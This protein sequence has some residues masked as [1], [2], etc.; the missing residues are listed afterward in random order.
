MKTI[1]PLH[2]DQ[3]DDKPVGKL[4]SRREVLALLGGSSAALILG[5]G[6]SSSLARQSQAT[7][8]PAGT[9]LPSCVVRPEMTEG[10]YF[11]DEQLNRID[12][13]IDPTDGNIKDGVPLWVVFNVSSVGDGTCTPIAGAQIDV[14]SCDA[15]GVY[16]GVSDAG[17]ETVGQKWLRG[18]QVTD[19]TG[20]AQ[21][22]SVFPGWYSGRT[23][24][25]HFK[26]RTD[27]SAE[28]S[29]EFTSQLFFPEELIDTVYAQA[30]YSTKSG[31]RDTTNATDMHYANGGDQLLMELTEVSTG[32]MTSVVQSA[33]ASVT[34]TPQAEVPQGYKIV[35]TI[36]LDLTDTSVGASDSFSQGGG[37]GAGGG[38][39]GN[40]PGGAP[41]ATP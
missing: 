7:S 10:P 2:D 32:D 26:I 1:R 38:P 5:T 16:S 33:A 23:T 24:H 40:P 29:Y 39:G 4:L 6:F 27:P 18:Y 12:V 19:D 35:F 8:T 34:A 13:R 14:W 15:V 37:P 25:F 9:A 20:A 30:P 21:F 31:T 11:V 3:D 28:T 41:T 22:I 36:G 17:F